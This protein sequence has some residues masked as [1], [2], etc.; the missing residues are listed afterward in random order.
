MANDDVLHV[1]VFPWLAMGHL[2]P[3]LNLSKLLAQKGHNVS[4]ISTP[5]NI[6]KLPKIPSHLSSFI[7]FVSLPFPHVPDHLPLHAESST[8]VPYSMQQL[9]K[10]AFDS[11]ELP[12]LSFLQTSKPDW[13]I[14]DYAP[15]WLPRLAAELGV[16]RAFFSLFNAANLAFIGPPSVLIDGRDSRTKAEDFAVVPEW[17]P[18]ETHVVYRTYEL[19]KYFEGTSV[20]EPTTADTVRFGVAVAG[21][22]VVAVRSCTEFEPD[23]FAL[24]G[25]LYQKPVV[26]IGFLPPVLVEDEDTKSDEDDKWVTIEEWLDK[27]KVNSVVY[28]A[29][30]TEANLT[31]EELSELALGLEISKLPF[32]LVL[33]KMSGSSRTELEMLP[34]GFTERVKDRGMVYVGW[35]PQVRILS[36]DSVGGFLTHC[37]WN[38]V[39]E[40][41]G[42]GR[43][44]VLLPLVNDQGLN[45][46]LLTGKGLGLEVPRNDLDGSFTSESVAETVRLAVVEDSGELL[47]EKAKE[48]RGLFG[49]GNRNDRNVDEFISFLKENKKRK[50]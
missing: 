29:L 35:A 18:F 39:I 15:H 2:I 25:E 41:L 12:L 48:M 42:S 43:V 40:G 24:L 7:N 37:G 23:W 14:Y 38:S 45:A 3:F 13:V 47:R 49:D 11:L 16:S 36:H 19:A 27:Q 17:I 30:G 28:V 1:V 32:L 6:L 31:C 20:Y 50:S 4:F 10:R 33:R 22:E 9:L 46:R 44:L 34:D 8:D 26:P 5:R 21:S